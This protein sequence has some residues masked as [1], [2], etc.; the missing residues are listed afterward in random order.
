MSEQQC[1]AWVFIVIIHQDFKQV[2]NGNSI[3]V[4]ATGSITSN[5]QRRFEFRRGQRHTHR[6]RGTD[7]GAGNESSD[8][9]AQRFKIYAITFQNC[10]GTC[11]TRHAMDQM[12]QQHLRRMQCL[13]YFMGRIANGKN[14]I[15]DPQG[16]AAVGAMRFNAIARTVGTCWL[17]GTFVVATL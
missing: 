11:H 7:G 5:A 3:A 17:I 12:L 2:L 16:G 8:I 15:I 13:S 14:S 9:T 4:T 1:H 6:I 10:A